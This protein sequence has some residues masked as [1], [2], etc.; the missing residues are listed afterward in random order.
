MGLLFSDPNHAFTGKK[1][2]ALDEG[3]IFIEAI[4][5]NKVKDYK[6]AGGQRLVIVPGTPGNQGGC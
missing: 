4:P 1:Q 3:C 5:P 6:L 2:S